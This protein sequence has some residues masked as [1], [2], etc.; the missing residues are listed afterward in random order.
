MDQFLAEVAQAEDFK[1][2]EA[3]DVNYKKIDKELANA[4]L[5]WEDAAHGWRK[6]SISINIPTG[7]KTL[8]SSS[9]E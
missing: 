3:K 1:L 7:K 4:S 2:E 8:E 9:K 6:T 5:P